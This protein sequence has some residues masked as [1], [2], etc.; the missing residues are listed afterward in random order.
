M[1]MSVKCCSQSTFTQSSS[2]FF[3]V[4]ARSTVHEPFSISNI[5]FY[6]SLSLN[7]YS[8]ITA[9]VSLSLY[10]APFLCVFHSLLLCP[11][12]PQHPQLIDIGTRRTNSINN[13]GHHHSRGSFYGTFTV[14]CDLRTHQTDLLSLSLF[15]W[16]INFI[17]RSLCVAVQMEKRAQHGTVDQGVYNRIQNVVVVSSLFIDRFFTPSLYAHPERRVKQ[18]ELQRVFCC[19]LLLLS[20]FFI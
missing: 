19:L 1:T 15:V 4:V 14:T 8:I 12:P 5:K 18:I 6:F 2:F 9:T 11:V 7:M 16:S 17:L 20:S 10:V 3:V 13:G